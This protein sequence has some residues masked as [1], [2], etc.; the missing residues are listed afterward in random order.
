MATEDG[1][2]RYDG[3]SFQ[4][5]GVQ[6]GL[7]VNN[8]ICSLEDKNSYLY[9][10]TSSGLF[11]K[12][13][14]KFHK[15]QNANTG[16]DISFFIN[17]LCEAPDGSIIFSTSGRGIWRIIDIDK[18]ENIIPADGYGQFVTQLVFD[19]KG[20]LWTVS[21]KKGVASFKMKK[22][23]DY[24]SFKMKKA[25][26]INDNFSYASI[27]LDSSDRVYVGASNGG[28]Y[29]LNSKTDSFSLCPSSSH[30]RVLSM[31]MTNDNFLMIGTNGKGLYVYNPA[32]GY[33]RPSLVSSRDVN[34]S[35][36]KVSSIFIDKTDNL[37]LGLF[38]K[39][40]FM[41]PPYSNTFHCLGILQKPVNVIGETYVLSVHS[42]SD[43]TLWISCDQEGLYCLDS[44]YNRIRHFLPL[45]EGGTVPA[46][47]VDIEENIDGKLWIGSYTEG[48]GWID[49]NTGAYHRAPFSY[50][51]SQSVFDIRHDK[52][53]NLWLGTLGDGLKK[54]N[55]FTDEMEVFKSAADSNSLCNDFILQMSFSKDG[56]YLYVGTSAGL[57]CYDIK[58]KSWLTALGR[59][60]ILRQ[61]AIN[62][63][64][65]D[66]KGNL[67][68]GTEQGLHCYNIK[69][70][71]TTV[72]TVAD[73][74]PDNHICAIEMDKTGGMWISTNNGLARFDPEKR[75][76]ECFY[77]SDG[78][79]GNEYS[80]GAS[81]YD[82]SNNKMYFA[83]TSGVSYFD[84]LMAKQGHKKLSVIISSIAV[85]GE[86]VTSFSKSGRFDICNEAVSL[87]DHFDFCHEDNSISLNFSTLTYS[88]TERL[89]YQYSING[90]SWIS[91]PSGEN[92]ISLF[93]LDPG[94]YKF[95]VKAVD[96]GIESKIKEFT[97][98]IHN[99]WYFTPV[100]RIIYLLLAIAVVI[101]Y[102]HLVRVRNESRLRLQE[103]I[104]K[105]ELN[106]QKLRFFI[107]IS[108]EIRTPMSLIISPL[109]QLIREEHDAQRQSIY[110]VM[111]R[112][113]ERIL[114][115]VN[116]ILDLRKIDEG[117]MRLQMQET[118]MTTFVEDILALFRPQASSKNITL[119]F[120]HSDEA[121]PVWIDRSNFSTVV[122]NLMSNAMK[123]TPTGG[124]IRVTLNYLPDLNCCQL[125]VFDNGEQIPEDSLKRIFERFHQVATSIN[126]SKVGTGIGLDLAKSL[127][128]L[129][130]GNIEVENV[131][132]GVNFTVTLPLGKEHLHEEEI[133]HFDEADMQKNEEEK[134]ME[135]ESA[136]DINEEDVAKMVKA[137]TGKRPTIVIV[138]D[139]DDIRDYLK[140]QL[141]ST[142]RVLSYT[143]GMEALPAIL[144]ELPQIVVSDVMMPNMDGNTLAAKIKANVNTNHIPVILLTAKTRDEDKLEGLETGADLYV[145]KP[146]NMDILRRHIV[147][148]IASRRLMQNK[149]TGK[150]DMKTDLDNVTLE[151]ADDKLLAR[152]MNVVNANLSN[153]DLNIDMICS[154]VGISRVHLH[155]K[156]KELT[157]Q[158]PHDFIRNLRLKQA[159]RLLSH[160]GQSITEVMYRCGFNSATSFSTMF[161]KMYGISPREYM[162][163]QSEEK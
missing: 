7:S 53:G 75:K 145:T 119:R 109:L 60:C 115:L 56:S 95:R 146:F 153:S 133:A 44:N 151:S 100:A 91:L 29:V 39:G 22:P 93:R 140:S 27:C 141:S 30:F 96:N 138:E 20:I 120:D 113:A 70:R 163:S 40:V 55:P 37:W 159:A 13:K 157:N 26:G 14:G 102:L 156:M 66:G 139:D 155:R 130:H 147:N 18:V 58:R 69:S 99:P 28:V 49:P 143:D 98:V 97:I 112:N 57:S 107:N 89:H 12:V 136:D 137:G 126:Q 25:Y 86:R 94:D 34:L 15:L 118:D 135:M 158:T 123:Y 154:E 45:N 9:V 36:S 129:H 23:N 131:N 46:A 149:F 67:W 108:H 51:N 101:W 161:K 142:Y 148:L 42:K 116:Q 132:D 127:V 84:P 110:V 19:H 4:R 134:L 16:Q 43:N 128:H 80:M 38:Q 24:K 122:I 64:L 62:A 48:F 50:G 74:L 1:L 33:S 150:E 71:K 35:K 105:E 90:E 81:F 73:G 88:G 54:Y 31:T 79:Q 152:I 21:E 103:H 61:K 121:M 8:I 6:D 78:L 76:A 52:K 83:G 41:Q 59:Q 5:F 11:V 77:V 111:K 85:S 117:Q 65:D 47:I 144:R 17:A 124:M 92:T 106:E 87:A 114:H 3:Y 10:G 68:L 82:R 63:I 160:K 162:K 72:Y 104:H 2:N 125:H 32:T